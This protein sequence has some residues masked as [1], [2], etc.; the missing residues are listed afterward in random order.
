MYPH[1]DD[2]KKV[3]GVPYH[4][5]GDKV[6]IFEEGKDPVTI[7]LVLGRSTYQVVHAHLFN[8]GRDGKKP[9]TIGNFTFQVED[10]VLTVY[11][12]NGDI[13]GTKEL[14]SDS[15]VRYPRKHAID[16]VLETF[17]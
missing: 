10:D 4:I 8:K 5:E 16:M 13:L 7:D 9:R 17:E 15:E 11:H 12:K 14:V 1:V 6:T 3:K 2:M